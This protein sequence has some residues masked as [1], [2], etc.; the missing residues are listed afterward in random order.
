MCECWVFA[1]ISGLE[2]YAE[3]VTALQQLYAM[4]TEM[5]HAFTEWWMFN[6]W[7]CLWHQWIEDLKQVRL[8][9]MQAVGA[10]DSCRP[11]LCKWGATVTDALG[12]PTLTSPNTFN[13]DDKCGF[14]HSGPAAEA[15]SGMMGASRSFEMSPYRKGA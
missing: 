13:Y 12:R 6:T 14:F 9:I 3:R 2:H 4:H 15:N 7:E 1:L 5:P 11:E 10:V 8:N